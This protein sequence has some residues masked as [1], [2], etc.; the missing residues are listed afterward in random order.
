[1]SVSTGASSSTWMVK[2]VDALLTPSL[3]VT[4]KVR[5]LTDG[6]FRNRGPMARGELMKKLLASYGRDDEFRAVAEQIIAEGLTVNGVE[7]LLETHVFDFAGDL[8]GREIEASMSI[9]G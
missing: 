1:M 5:N 7:P 6:R 9:A 4:G 2:V 8:Y 3:T